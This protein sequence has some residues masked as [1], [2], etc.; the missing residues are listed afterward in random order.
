MYICGVQQAHIFCGKR[1]AFGNLFWKLR[2]S[3]PEGEI[4]LQ[5]IPKAFAATMSVI[6]LLALFSGCGNRSDYKAEFIETVP[7][8]DKI[9]ERIEEELSVKKKKLIINAP[10]SIPEEGGLSEVR[11]A[12]SEAQMKDML[13]GFFRAE[14][15]EAESCDQ[16]NEGALALWVKKDDE[17]LKLSFNVESNGTVG[18]YNAEKDIV[19]QYHNAGNDE[20]IKVFEEI[21]AEQE[22]EARDAGELASKFLEGYSCFSFVPQKIVSYRGT[23]AEEQAY[24]I[25]LQALYK[26][27]PVIAE[28]IDNNP[29]IYV[30]A[31]LK[32][33][34][35]FD[36][37]GRIL[38][39]PVDERKLEKVAVFSSV[40]DFF[41]EKIA[42]IVEGETIE[43]KNISLCYAP[44]K[45]EDGAVLLRPAWVFTCCD[46][47]AK[48]LAWEKDLGY[49]PVKKYYKLVF[50]VESGDF[51][52]IIPGG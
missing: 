32:N 7:W 20:Q 47:R 41:K 52:G 37:R 45:T 22:Q 39:E 26:D 27:I 34:L 16:L 13:E 15:P 38:L 14:Y 4:E 11:L 28:S 2:P 50:F 42:S 9:P 12:F 25:I 48:L 40:L 36:F 49:G 3:S 1:R 24:D 44:L 35:I 10:V 8:K 30:S 17:E 19:A 29:G 6:L 51:F 18:F 23:E 33:S 31:R 43:L 21:P 5:K 46:T